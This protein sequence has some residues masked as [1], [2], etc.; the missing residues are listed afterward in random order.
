MFS[1]K[2][3]NAAEKGPSSDNTQK[4]TRYFFY[5]PTYDL[6]NLYTSSEFG[7]IIIIFLLF[8]EIGLRENGEVQN[9]LVLIAQVVVFKA[10]SQIPHIIK[11]L[12]DSK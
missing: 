3:C 11:D 12:K 10:C 4:C 6:H 5:S 1:Q 2:T 9:N 7:G 8:M